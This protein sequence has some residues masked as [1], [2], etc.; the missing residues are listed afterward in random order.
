MSSLFILLSWYFLSL[1]SLNDCLS[2]E[3]TLENQFP[4]ICGIKELN[5][6]KSDMFLEAMLKYC[7]ETLV[8]AGVKV[9]CSS[10]KVS[11][12]KVTNTKHKRT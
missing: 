6:L 10:F 7:H 12:C 9:K 11:H 5:R 4:I 2:H 3:V 8:Y 1:P